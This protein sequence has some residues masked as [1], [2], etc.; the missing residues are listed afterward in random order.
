M[1]ES[2]HGADREIDAAKQNN[3]RHADRHHAEHRD[4]VH[5]VEDAARRR[6]SVGAEAQE[7]A[8][9]DQADQRPRHASDEA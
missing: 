9:Q 1:A 5:D 7:T 6:E 2:Q 4:L 3:Q 8:K